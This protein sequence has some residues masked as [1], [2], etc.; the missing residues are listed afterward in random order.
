M[1]RAQEAPELILSDYSGMEDFGVETLVVLH[2]EGGSAEEFVYRGVFGGGGGAQYVS[3]ADG[4]GVG[5]EAETAAVVAGEGGATVGGNVEWVNDAVVLGDV[6][7]VYDGGP[8]F[9]GGAIDL[10]VAEG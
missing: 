7:A 4:C 3:D 1:R 9:A 8:A 2:V 10:L 6:V 5:A